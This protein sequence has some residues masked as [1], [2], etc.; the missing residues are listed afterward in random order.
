MAKRGQQ[1]VTESPWELAVVLLISA[2]VF[3][4]I[5][6]FVAPFLG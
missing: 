3:F 4:S 5:W 2:T 1:A 6:H